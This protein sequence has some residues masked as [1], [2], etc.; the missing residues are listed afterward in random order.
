[1]TASLATSNRYVPRRSTRISSDLGHVGATF[2]LWERTRLTTNQTVTYQPFY[3]LTLF[4][5]AI[6]SVSSIEPPRHDLAVGLE[7]YFT[8]STDADISHD[9]SERSSGGL[10]YGYVKTA[11]GSGSPDFS[12]QRAGTHLSRG[13]TSRLRLNFTYRHEQGRYD[14]GSNKRQVYQESLDGGIDYTRRLTAFSRTTLSAATG[15]TAISERGH[16][17]YRVVGSALLSREVGRTWTVALGYNRSSRFLET[18]G[19]PLF[20]DA[21]SLTVG[22]LINR[23]MQLQAT[24]GASKGALGIT[25][26]NDMTT[27]YDTIALTVGFTRLFGFRIDYSS[28]TYSFDTATFLPPGVTRNQ[29]R[30]TVAASL[31]F[32]VPVK[33]R[34]TQGNAPR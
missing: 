10:S 14:D 7:D 27:Y 26:S 23:R 6:D 28:F 25:D 32:W 3:T 5:E 15:S 33:Y 12:S 24:G 31:T 4:P 20:E 2:Q 9:F 34:E 13:L 17:Y 30:Q 16:T 1:L 19:A 11:F 29:Q 21:A 18:F 8:S 22:G